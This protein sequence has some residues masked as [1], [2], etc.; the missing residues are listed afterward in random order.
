MM[1]KP[2]HQ[3][4]LGVFLLFQFAPLAASMESDFAEGVKWFKQAQ[5][6]T[7]VKHFEAARSQGLES[8]ALHYNL[9]SSYYKLGRYDQAKVYFQ[10][11]LDVADMRQLSQY[12]LG[13]IALRQ[14]EASRARDYFSAIVAA[15]TDAKLQSLAE[16]Q[17]QK[18]SLETATGA[19]R[20]SVYLAAS[21]GYN[22]NISALPEDALTDA[23]GSFYSLYLS[24][25]RVISGQRNAGWLVDL[26]IYAVDFTGDGEHDDRQYDLGIKKTLQLS[27][28]QSGFQLSLLQSD[29]GGG[30][31]Q[32]VYK[33]EATANKALSSGRKIHL[34]YRLEDIHSDD[35]SY[36]YL[37]GQRHKIRVEYKKYSA[38][39]SWQFYY[40]LETNDRAQLQTSSYSYDYSPRRN[41]LYGRYGYY[42][43]N[44][45]QLAGDLSYRV[46]D[47][48]ASS[49]MDREDRQLR[50]AL[51]ADYRFNRTLKLLTRLQLT[52]NDSSEDIYTYQQAVFKIGLSQLF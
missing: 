31:Y 3:T 45:W 5:Y 46:S 1:N 17:L 22:D 10:G 33:L 26:S 42:L 2:V 36:D 39:D 32:S 4:L 44:H 13:L 19:D 41:T 34:R 47:F 14:N 16:S 25:D 23:A 8:V 51:N 37:D 12:N 43:G 18:L 35:V 27:D 52:D 24:A 49:S 15:D 40:E 30:D 28:W 21:L 11:L 9:G 48:P 38:A 29:Y 6:T 50:V 20:G 7:A